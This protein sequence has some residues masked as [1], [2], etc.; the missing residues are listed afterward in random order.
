MAGWRG[1][2]TTAA[3]L[4]TW[5]TAAADDAA[6]DL[7]RAR[8]LVRE[9]KAGELT[10]LARRKAFRREDPDGI[11]R[12]CAA[13]FLSV[14]PIDASRW[15]ALARLFGMHTEAVRDLLLPEYEGAAQPSPSL[16]SWPHEGRVDLHIAVEAGRGRLGAAQV[17]LASIPSPKRESVALGLALI[18]MHRAAADGD[19]AAV[20][21]A[22]F[23][24]IRSS[25]L[26]AHPLEGD[27][28]A[29]QVRRAVLL[30]SSLPEAPS[31]LGALFESLPIVRSGEGLGRSGRGA[32]VGF[33]RPHPPA[34]AGTVLRTLLSRAEAGADLGID[35]RILVEAL[36]HRDLAEL[37]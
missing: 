31:A 6:K 5:G 19:A 4:L 34:D 17:H 9:R 14:D 23:P 24:T 22:A 11:W 28:L 26:D 35:R 27:A 1:C 20:V 33:L 13:H 30:L 2:V 3:L 25:A 32:I 7:D 8:V 29:P 16:G 21:R 18:A 15:A 12:E 10:S 37:P 36:E